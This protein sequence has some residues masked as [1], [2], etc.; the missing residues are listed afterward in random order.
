MV[1]LLLLC[2]RPAPSA[3]FE[4]PDCSFCCF[5][6]IELVRDIVFDPGRVPPFDRIDRNTGYDDSKVE[7]VT[8]GHAG[9]SG[10]ADSLAFFHVVPFLNYHL[11]QVAVEGLQTQAMVD[12]D[13]LTVNAQVAGMDNPAAIGGRHRRMGKGGQVDPQVSLLINDFSL[14][15]ISAGL[16][17]GTPWGGVGQPQERPLPERHG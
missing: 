15:Q 5:A 2:P 8:G 9:G 13:A 7:M 10:V 4:L 12:Y 1:N 3:L 16:A 11:A 14:I 17:E 6:H